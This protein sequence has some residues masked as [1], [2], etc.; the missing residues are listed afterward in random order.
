MQDVLRPAP[1]ESADIARL[2]VGIEQL[3]AKHAAPR[4]VDRDGTDITIPPSIFGA[5][6]AAVEAMSRGEAITLVPADQPL[7]TQAAADLLMVSRPHLIKLLD[8]GDIPYYRVGSHR[9]I[10]ISDVL[11]YREQRRVA[12]RDGLTKLTR[13]SQDMG[14]YD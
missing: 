4:L 10:R 3:C 6:R 7:T 5:L 13:E 11:T 9:R 12:R 14:G 8:R 1:E 2:H